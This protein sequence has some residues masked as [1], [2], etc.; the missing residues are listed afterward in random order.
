MATLET[1][2]AQLSDASILSRLTLELGFDC[3]EITMRSRLARLRDDPGQAIF[4]ASINEERPV[5]W[6]HVEVSRHLWHDP[7]VVITGLVVRE[8]NRRHGIGRALVQRASVW[9]ESLGIPDL[10]AAVQGHRDAAHELF[11]AL[12]F[13]AFDEVQIWRRP[14]ESVVDPAGSPTLVD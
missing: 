13:E 8:G 3:N 10:R 9:A 5:G 11:L 6:L 2:Q 1:R 14:M 7:Y 12:G 4:V